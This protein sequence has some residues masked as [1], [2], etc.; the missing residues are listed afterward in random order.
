MPPEPAEPPMLS[1][2]WQPAFQKIGQPACKGGRIRQLLAL[3]NAGLV[4]EQKG[5]LAELLGCALFAD[6]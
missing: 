3:D 4:E 5:E 6:R 1:R 2:G